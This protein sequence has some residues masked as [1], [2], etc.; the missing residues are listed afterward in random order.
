[1][2]AY[3]IASYLWQYDTIKLCGREGDSVES[4][5]FY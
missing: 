2:L 5:A 1:M 4:F 3:S